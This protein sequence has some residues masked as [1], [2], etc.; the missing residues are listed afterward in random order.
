MKNLI[1]KSFVIF[2]AIVILTCAL[3][4][5]SGKDKKV[6]GTVGAYEVYYE[7]LR[8]LTMQYKDIMASTYGED[9]W[10]N[11]DTAEQYRAELEERVYSSIISNYVILTLCDDDIISYT[12]PGKVQTYMAAGR[13]IIAS[14]KG[15]SKLVIEKAG[16]GFCAPP[17]N[18]EALADAV[19][20][21][22]ALPREKRKEM[23]RRAI[24]FYQKN[25]SK[26]LFVKKLILELEELCN[27]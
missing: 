22:A 17:E 27:S 5:C 26:E 1:K 21:F 25:Y 15:E 13:P 7:E 8:W 3:T 6:V 4:S 19:R 9:I 23:G 12:L 11:K 16:C 18:A 24:E 20:S 14:A 10:K 2:L